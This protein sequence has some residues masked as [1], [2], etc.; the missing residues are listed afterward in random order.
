MRKELSE[1]VKEKRYALMWMVLGFL[2]LIH[3]QNCGPAP[4]DMSQFQIDNEVRV[5]DRWSGR[6]GFSDPVYTVRDSSHGF[7]LNGL[8]QGYDGDL[9]EWEVVRRVSEDQVERLSVGTS[10]CTL[11]QF[12]VQMSQVPLSS[13]Y[14]FVYLRAHVER[15]LIGE[16]QISG[17]C[18]N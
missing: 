8:C 9:I 12:R 11:S 5:S 1:K 17:E 2:S 13:C 6:V 14:D 18:V 7:T 3:F 4:T 16:T 15:A 10:A